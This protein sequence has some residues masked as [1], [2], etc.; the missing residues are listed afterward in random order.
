MSVV[1][2]QIPQ[3]WPNP[4]HEVEQFATA[5]TRSA[6]SVSNSQ[7]LWALAA[8]V[9]GRVNPRSSSHPFLTSDGGSRKLPFDPAD[10]AGVNTGA[11]CQR[12]A[13]RKAEPG[14]EV[15]ASQTPGSSMLFG[16]DKPIAAAQ[17]R[18]PSEPHYPLSRPVR[19]PDETGDEYELRCGSVTSHERNTP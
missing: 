5:Q 15:G 4:G 3:C 7:N 8:G 18:G 9:G 1:A 13:N 19:R 16:S 10:A 12:R 6:S 14:L 17:A 11:V 2:K